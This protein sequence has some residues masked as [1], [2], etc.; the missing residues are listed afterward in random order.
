MALEIKP[1]P[2]LKSKVAKEFFERAAECKEAL[3]RE[4]VQEINRQVRKSL[5][6]ARE[7]EARAREAREKKDQEND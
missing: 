5:E 2:V 6:E 1:L 4:E 7:R 3:S